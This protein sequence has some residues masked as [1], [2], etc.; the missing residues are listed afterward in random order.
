MVAAQ[1]QWVEQAKL[2]ER[3]KIAQEMHDVLAHR[4]S[5]LALLAGGLAYRENLSPEQTCEAA[6]AIQENA[7]QSLNELRAVLGTLRREDGLAPPQPTLAHLDA[8]FDEV[9][10]AGQRVEVDDAISC[11]DALP[12]QTGRHAYRIVQEALTNARKHAPGSPVPAELG[13]RPGE[14]LRIRVS[15][16]APPGGPTGPGGGWAWWGWRN[17]PGWPVARSRMPYE[18]GDLSWTPGCRGRLEPVIRVVIVDDDPMVRT[19]L[20]LILGG[21]PDLDLA[22]EA[23]DGKQAMDVIRDLRPDVVLMDI[24]M[25][26]QDGLVARGEPVLS[27]S[28]A[29]QVIAAATGGHKPR[30]P[31]APAELAVLTERE[32]EVAI[33]VARGASNAEIAASLSVSVATVKANITRIFAKLGTDNRVHVAMKVRDAGLL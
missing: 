25:P 31:R 3:L 28:V 24:R 26:E 7:H 12:A 5:L 8:L 2:E 6:L 15:N 13:G 23:G 20:R 11:R 21:E 33:E 30:R 4:I 19:G 1:A 27:P 22:G 14:G 32:R 10:A 29:R 17:G 16:A 9:R 18:M